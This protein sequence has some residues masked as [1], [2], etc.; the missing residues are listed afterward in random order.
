MLALPATIAFRLQHQTSVHCWLNV[1]KIKCGLQLY[2]EVLAFK[3][4]G[5]TWQVTSDEKDSGKLRNTLLHARVGYFRLLS[6]LCANILPNKVL[7]NKF[8]AFFYERKNDDA[9][10]EWE[11]DERQEMDKALKKSDEALE[12]SEHSYSQRYDDVALVLGEN[13]VPLKQVA[14][15]PA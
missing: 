14:S 12:N 9:V 1:I 10:H 15:L 5:E 2:G 3:V 11:H 8:C 6:P 7:M 4:P 13:V